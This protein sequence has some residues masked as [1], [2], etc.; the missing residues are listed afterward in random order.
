MEEKNTLWHK[1]LE[2]EGVGMLS[3]LFHEFILQRSER[4]GCLVWHRRENLR[5]ED[6]DVLAEG[7]PNDVQIISAIAKGARERHVH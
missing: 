6:I 4:L 2:G 7:Q 5:G 1:Y 3:K